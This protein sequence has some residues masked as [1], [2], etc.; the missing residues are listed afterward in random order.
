MVAPLKFL[1]L[2][3][4][5]F[6]YNLHLKIIFSETEESDNTHL[7]RIGKSAFEKHAK[8]VCMSTFCELYQTSNNNK[9]YH[10]ACGELF[11]DV[12]FHYGTYS[13]SSTNLVL[14]IDCFTVFSPKLS[15]IWQNR[16]VTCGI[17]CNIIKPTEIQ[18]NS[19]KDNCSTVILAM[20][21]SEGPSVKCHLADKGKEGV[22]NIS[23]MERK[24]SNR[25][26][27][28]DIFNNC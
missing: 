28:W 27:F 12:P 20:L 21:C 9:F 23:V 14:Q 26:L 24:R 11:E 19:L 25:Y 3:K 13:S 1:D 4:C 2:C 17:V 16:S 22:L 8:F 15:A 10:I 18:G 5:Q 7:F 6:C